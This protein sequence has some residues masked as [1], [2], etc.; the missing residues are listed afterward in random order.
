MKSLFEAR[1]T[2]NEQT[3]WDRLP[4]AD[5]AQPAAAQGLQPKWIAGEMER[6]VYQTDLEHQH[7]S[8]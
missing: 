7:L 5:L 4:R 6:G 2:V 3:R 1:E 8:R